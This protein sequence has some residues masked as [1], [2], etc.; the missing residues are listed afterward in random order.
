MAGSADT[1]TE[2]VSAEV[3]GI[4]APNEQPASASVRTAMR[5]F[6]REGMA[7]WYFY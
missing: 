7:A 3:A 1:A 6:I 5:V 2:E 4:R